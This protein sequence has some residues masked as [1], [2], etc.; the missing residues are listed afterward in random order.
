[1]ELNMLTRADCIVIAP[2][3]ATPD[4][5]ILLL[6]TRLKA[7]GRIADRELYLRSV[8]E[9]EAE[10]PTALGEELAVPHGKSPAVLSA[11]FA[12]AIL[13]EA[14]NWPGLEGD[15]PVRLVF[16][17]AIPPAE[18]G[19][20]HMQLL[21]TLTSRLT[22]DLCRQ[23]LMAA[24]SPEHVFELLSATEDAA[25][26]ESHQAVG[27]DVKAQQKPGWLTPFLLA[28]ISLAAV[29]M[30]ALDWAGLH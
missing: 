8:R 28:G 14:I 9:R 26:P 12:L 27:C 23:Q 5:V 7:A 22:D 30:A 25:P 18:A 15:E 21:T 24:T 17:L 3:V 20:T 4:D 19:S 29:V 10:G 16:L 2:T 6:A 13:P 11:S 1:M